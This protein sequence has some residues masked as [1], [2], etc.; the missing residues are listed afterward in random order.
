MIN[1]VFLGGRL[2]SKPELK[3]F[4]G[5]VL[6]NFNIAVNEKR[7]TGEKTHWFKITCFNK[8]AEFLVKHANKGDQVVV[9]GRLQQEEFTNKEGQKVSI[10]SV[11]ASSVQLFNNRGENTE[12]PRSAYNQGQ[13]PRDFASQSTFEDDIPW[14]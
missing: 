12:Q 10:V 11:T 3:S 9:E 2:G 8:T 6:T 14:T 1:T 7:K 4:N 5:G 13:E